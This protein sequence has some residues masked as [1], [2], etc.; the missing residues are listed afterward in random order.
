MNK[1]IEVLKAKEITQF[2]ARE[3][4][5]EE[6]KANF[7]RR[8]E[9]TRR[10]KS[11]RAVIQIQLEKKAK[12][13]ARDYAKSWLERRTER[14]Q[15][16]WPSS[17]RKKE[18][19]PAQGQRCRKC[20]KIGHFGNVCQS[21]QVNQISL[22][23]VYLYIYSLA[24]SKTKEAFV[25]FKVN[26]KQDIAFQ[27]DTGATCNVLLF[28]EYKRATGDL[29]GRSLCNTNAVLIMH[30]KSKVIPEGAIP[31]EL[32]RSCHGYQVQLVPVWVL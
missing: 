17:S 28:E 3:I 21:S 27:I 13:P 18:G 12:F 6:S 10:E 1:C 7:V 9:E 22:E 11:K 23:V 14:L 16:L 30:N 19:C 4:S 24:N 31:L 2:H 25:T 32:N 26:K 8:S 29:E 15:V 20:D 5:T